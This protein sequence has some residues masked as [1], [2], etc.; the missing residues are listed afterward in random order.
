MPAPKFVPARSGEFVMALF[1]WNEKLSVG[2]PSID[3]QHKKLVT[4]I[5][6]LHDGMMAGK[7][8]EVVG[9]VLKGLIEYTATHF[10]YEEQ[11]F[12]KTGYAEAADH[13]KHH[14]DLVRQVMDIQKKYEQSGPNA[15]TI[16]VMNFLKEWLTGHIL[17]A[18][19]RYVAHLTAKG[20][21]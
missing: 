2:I 11:L 5:N 21:N 18:D 12:A 1:V 16:Q 17:G 19:K 15:L 8:K 9:P 4:F 7:G 3:N 14:D 13:K 10:K 6:Q 20:V